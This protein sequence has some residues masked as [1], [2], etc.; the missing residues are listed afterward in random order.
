MKK[1]ILIIALMGFTLTINAQTVEDALRFSRTSLHGTARAVSMGGAFGALGGDLSSISI[2]PAGIGVFRRPEVSYT[3][4]LT[5]NKTQSG[6]LSAKS[7]SYLPDNV[8]GVLIMDTDNN[9]FQTFNFGVSYSSLANLNQRYNQAINNS[10]TS[11]TDVYAAQSQGI[12]PENLNLLN[13][14]L[15]Y[16]SFL[17]FQ[18]EDGSYHSILETDGET[19]ELVNQRKA[20]REKGI[21]GEMAISAGTNCMDKL[22]LGVVIG[23]RVLEY[24]MKSTYTEVAEENAP[25]QLDFYNFNESRKL[26]GIG[27]NLKLGAIYRPIPEIR[28]GAAI[29]SPTWYGVEHTLEN[30]V[31]STFATSNDPSVGR[32]YID[33]YYSSAEYGEFY[34][35]HIFRSR[36]RTPWRSVLSFGSVIAQR[37]IVS[38]DYEY[39]NYTKF[40]Y[41]HPSRM[42]YKEYD[43]DYQAEEVE[44]LSKSMDYNPVNADINA[45]YR[46][47]HNFRAGAELRI[48]NMVSLRGGY[49]FQ[50]S[51]YRNS[52]DLGKIKSISGGLGLKF[53][54][55]FFD[56]AYMQNYSKDQSRFYNYQG[57]AALPITNKYTNR[58]F[59][60]TVGVKID[61]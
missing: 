61:D 29:H 26:N 10:P 39:I 28:L 38:M 3:S 5:F 2:N 56:L 58:E 42:A 44:A 37:M 47:T 46:P 18:S 50:D 13:T 24:K 52:G 4:S 21:F 9:S 31:Y 45:L 22:Y 1:I 25:S 57:I 14:A 20:I 30:S 54:I 11:L 41:R 51:P 36:M 16:D 33:Y 15:F 40:K 49:N 27:F 17:T 19:A 6:D 59:L 7:T 32:E 8:G 43:D 48:T 34:N 35:P 12:A 53:G 60:L 23:I 55:L